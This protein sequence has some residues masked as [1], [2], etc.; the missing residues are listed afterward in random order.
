MISP[1]FTKKEF[2]VV[3]WFLKPFKFQVLLIFLFFFIYSILEATSVGAFFPLIS[4][5]LSDQTNSQP[6]SGSILS[7]LDYLAMLIPIEE[8]I[9]AAGVLL[10]ITVIISNLFGFFSESFSAWHRYKLL[11]IFKNKTYQKI[12]E[13]NY[14]FY[15][16]KKQGDLVYIVMNASQ[17]VGDMLLFFPKIG[18]EIFRIL[19]ISVLL[20]SISTK[21]TVSVFTVVGIFGLFI[22]FLS[23]LVVHPIAVRLQK[24]ESAMTSIFS[25]SIAGIRQIKIFD[26][27]EIWMKR[28]R[29]QNELVRIE[30][31]KSSII[32]YLPS[33]M[34][35]LVGAFSVVMS[36]IYVKLVF[37]DNFNQLLPVIAVYIIALQKLMPAI[38]S[39]GNSWM[40]L[41]GLGP[42][43]DVTHATL[44][45]E[46]YVEEDGSEVF[47][48]MSRDIVFNDMSFSYPTRQN[49]L[50]NINIHV[51]K[52]QTVGIVG[53]SGSGKSTLVDLIMRLY[54]PTKG[55]INIDGKSC[56]DFIRS[57]WLEHIA[58]VSQDTFIFHESVRDNIKIGNLKACE[59]DVVNAAKIANAHQFIMELPEG[60]GTLLGDRGVKLSGGQRQRIAIARAVIRNPQ[61][62]ILD[63]ATSSLDNQSEKQ[64][65]QALKKAGEGRTNIIIAHRLSTIQHADNIF[66]MDKGKIVE[67]GTHEELMDLKGQ[68]W[69]LQQTQTDEYKS[70]VNILAG[71]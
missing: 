25:E 66:V 10:F 1:L 53:S 13:N 16:V 64:V 63:E 26:D 70:Q 23:V 51:S 35:Q 60:Y 55:N 21:V 36:I 18:V 43:L 67:E 34:I 61:I 32:G 7:F 57:S 31:T 39:I 22:H 69:Y 19:A 9:I 3:L 52:K 41:K 11:E 48:G 30:S 68:Y 49:V 6:Y 5:I 37:P 44:T 33:R 42:R 8:K 29:K 65:Q 15:L 46:K 28:F 38:A 24:G 17:S 27:I 56:Q 47:P 58:M 50:K 20:F 59:E 45:E 71:D 62:L 4:E 12:I 14:R 2:L 40:S 54:T